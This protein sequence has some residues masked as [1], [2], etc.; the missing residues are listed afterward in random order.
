MNEKEK[1]AKLF[2]RKRNMKIFPTYKMLAWDYLFFY[3]IDFLFLTQ[4]KGISTSDIVLKTSF[5]ALFNILLQIPASIIVEFLGRKNSIVLANIL[6]CMYIVMLMMSNAL[7]D[8]IISDFVAAMAFSIKNTAEPS[9]LNSSIPPSKYKSKIFSKITRRG[10]TGFYV[11]SSISKIIAGCLFNINYYL[12]LICSL[13]VLILV[14]F[15]SLFLVEP[16]RKSGK[17]DIGY[18][19]SIREIKEGFSYVVKVDRLKALILCSAMISAL[20]GILQNCSTSLYREIGLTAVAIGIISACGSM[21]SSIASRR[22]EVFHKKFRNK[23]LMTISTTLA[24]A[25]IISGLCGVNANN[26][27]FLIIVTVGAMWL[28]NFSH[29]MY[30]TIIDKYLRNFTNKN[31]DTK[32]FAANNLACNSLR[33]VFGMLAS[34]LLGKM[35]TAYCLIT[36]GIAFFI[37]YILIGKYMKTRVGKKPSEYSKEELKYDELHIEG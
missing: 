27:T 36:L 5:Y 11:L 34:F 35:S 13:V 20:L 33:F 31:I 24:S 7:V 22:Q 17:S 16:V 37:M 14:A 12:P 28:Y 9:L 18:K 1:E 10:M 32:I 23:S 8:L 21:I 6:N 26:N 25:C 3:A 2:M 19:K 15:M 30:Y 4:V 29:G